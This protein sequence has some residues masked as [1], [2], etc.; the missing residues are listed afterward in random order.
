LRLRRFRRQ[1]SFVA[2]K[3]RA[4]GT[5]KTNPSAALRGPPTDAKALVRFLVRPIP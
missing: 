2:I 1:V 5:P 3:T 4:Q